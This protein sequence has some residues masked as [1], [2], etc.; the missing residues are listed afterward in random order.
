MGNQSKTAN[1]KPGVDEQ[2][3]RIAGDTSTRMPVDERF[4]DDLREYLLDDQVRREIDKQRH[5]RKTS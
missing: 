2:S 4:L 5:D 1:D 3:S